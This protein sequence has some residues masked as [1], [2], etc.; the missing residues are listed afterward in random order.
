MHVRR[1]A[2]RG[3]WEERDLAGSERG[4]IYPQRS[5]HSSIQIGDPA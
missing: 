3:R 1:D 4:T 5:R 2:E